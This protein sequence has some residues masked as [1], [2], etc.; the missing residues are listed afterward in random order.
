MHQNSSSLPQGTGCGKLILFGEHAVVW[1]APALV[2]SLELGA[3]AS[4][5]TSSDARSSLTLLDASTQAEIATLSANAETGSSLERAFATILQTL[6]LDAPVHLDVTLHVPPGAGLGSSAA[7]AVAMARAIAQH[8]PEAAPYIEEAVAASEAIFHASASG[9]DQAAA[10]GSGLIR[11][12]KGPPTVL[13]ALHLPQ[14]V[15]VAICLAEPGASTAKMVQH[16]LAQRQRH[17][18]LFEHFRGAVEA[19]VEEAIEALQQDDRARIGELMNLNHGLLH[20]M[21]LSTPTIERAIEAAKAC[22]ALGAKLTGAGGGGCLYAIGANADH[23]EEIV[24]HLKT[25]GFHAFTAR[26]T[27]SIDHTES[28]S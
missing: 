19:I 27:P 12:E 24:A 10:M 17:P 11:F 21:G 28:S 15:E 14:A 8:T 25:S 4:L 1:G 22:G 20:G 9:I 5:S 26:I 3:H 2:T 7:M 13:Q 23:T 6:P 18:R 16:V